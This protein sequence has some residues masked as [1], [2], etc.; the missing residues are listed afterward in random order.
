MEPNEY[1]INIALKDNDGNIE[2][3]E[4]SII[5][6]GDP[7][8]ADT[9]FDS[10]YINLTKGITQSGHWNNIDGTPVEVQRANSL[11]SVSGIEYPFN[12]TSAG[13]WG[14]YSD[15]GNTTG[16]NSG[17]YPDNVI[18]INWYV[19]QTTG[20][21]IIQ[22]LYPDLLYSFT[23]F[24]S[25]K[26]ATDNKMT[27]FSID[28]QKQTL[29]A[30][31]NTHN[32]VQ[33]KDIYP[34]ENGEITISIKKVEGNDHGFFAAMVLGLMRNSEYEKPQLPKETMPVEDKINIVEMKPIQIYP[35]PFVDEFIINLNQTQEHI[36]TVQLF[37]ITGKQVGI[38][39]QNFDQ[40]AKIKVLSSEKGI[41]L[42][43]VVT[44]S[45]TYYKRMVLLPV[46]WK[47]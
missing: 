29:E 28:G 35:N 38:S 18:K 44:S 37:D 24:G 14:G 41:Y 16:D 21:V 39:V 6:T 17:I 25:R 33:F 7:I 12:F 15:Q 23:L 42:F 5:S 34:D 43:R 13:Q 11:I 46:V 22:N 10:I 40:G 4:R 32:T 45:N 20:K 27:E 47:D 30:A 8:A 3:I 26:G 36:K 31:S 2:L 9:Y 19:D 1:N